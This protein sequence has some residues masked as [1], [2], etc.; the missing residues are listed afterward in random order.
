MLLFFRVLTTT[1]YIK[2][3]VV[4]INGLR[5]D[6]TNVITDDIIKEA[7][8]DYKSSDRKG[9]IDLGDDDD[10]SPQLSNENSFRISLIGTELDITII[11]QM[12]NEV[13]AAF[14]HRYQGKYQ[15]MLYI[16]CVRA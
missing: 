3:I 10:D 13:A 8:K 2:K 16:I 9:I 14:V 5:I 12:E 1:Y 7:L 11:R 15:C 4:Y 6:L